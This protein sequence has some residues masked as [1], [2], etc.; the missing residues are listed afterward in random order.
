MSLR[1]LVSEL[2]LGSQ[3]LLPVPEP[4]PCELED[5]EPAPMSGGNMTLFTAF[6]AG[7]SNVAE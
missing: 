5:A 7:L 6:S 3:W 2:G 1:M 4:V